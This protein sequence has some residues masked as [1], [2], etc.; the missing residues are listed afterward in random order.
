MAKLS[1]TP[2]GIPDLVLQFSFIFGACWQKLRIKQ[3]CP[4]SNWR[5]SSGMWSTKAS[6]GMSNRKSRAACADWGVEEAASHHLCNSAKCDRAREWQQGWDRKWPQKAKGFDQQLLGNGSNL[7]GLSTGAPH[8]SALLRIAE[9]KRHR[10]Q[11]LMARQHMQANKVL[12]KRALGFL[13]R[14]QVS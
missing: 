7:L 14:R 5:D 8:R 2:S 10:D 11:A 1:S 6:D 4:L 3:C 9:A 12:L 13:Q